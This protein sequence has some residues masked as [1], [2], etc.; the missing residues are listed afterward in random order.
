MLGLYDSHA[1]AWYAAEKRDGQVAWA[2]LPVS[3]RDQ[4]RARVKRVLA[5]EVSRSQ[6]S[7]GDIV[8]LEGRVRS[9]FCKN[10]FYGKVRTTRGMN[11]EEAGYM[12]RLH[13]ATE[14]RWVHFYD[15]L[16]FGGASY[17]AY[18]PDVQSSTRLFGNAHIGRQELS[19]LMCGGYLDNFQQA[20]LLQSQYVT[21][22]GFDEAQEMQV[23][24]MMETSKIATIMGDMPQTTY[25]GWDLFTEPRPCALILPTRQHICA[26]VDF[27]GHAYHEL[28][29]VCRGYDR[30][31]RR[32]RLVVHYE[33]WSLREFA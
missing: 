10:P 2:D 29:L 6:C 22:E 30:E 27:Y 11:T 14:S 18:G 12:P 23:R 28:D 4:I 8:V 1:M 3:R 31:R 21:V 7:I 19:N 17:E 13:K 15:S 24:R 32:P 9:D 5:G 33:G 16:E 20:N 25:S 26:C